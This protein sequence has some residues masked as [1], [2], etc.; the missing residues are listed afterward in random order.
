M[1][2]DC[3]DGNHPACD[4]C[5]CTHLCACGNPPGPACVCDQDYDTRVGNW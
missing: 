5:D 4:G 1:C 3:L 2:L